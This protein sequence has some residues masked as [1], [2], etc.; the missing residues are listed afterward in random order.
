M[1]GARCV[2]LCPYVCKV[3]KI[4]VDGGNANLLPNLFLQEQIDENDNS[5]GADAVACDTWVIFRCTFSSL[6]GYCDLVAGTLACSEL[7][8]FISSESF[9]G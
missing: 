4:M 9:F 5:D 1:E 8:P 7:P 6:H 3:S 2:V